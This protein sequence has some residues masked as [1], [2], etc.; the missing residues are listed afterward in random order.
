MNK[1]IGYFNGKQTTVEDNTSYG[2]LQKAI[3]IFKQKKKKKHMVHV[4]I[5][6]KDGKPVYHSTA[7]L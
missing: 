7:S 3:A 2:D 1:Y 6:E 4:H 5:H